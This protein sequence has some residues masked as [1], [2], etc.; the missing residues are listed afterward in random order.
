MGWKDFKDWCIEY[1]LSFLPASPQT[2]IAYLTDR[3]PTM[4]VKTLELRLLAIRNEHRM[5]RLDCYSNH[6][7][8]AQTMKGI[9]NVHGKPPV[10]KTPILLSDL[11]EMVMACKDDL[12]GKRDK[13]LL[14]LGFAGAFRR[15]ELV[16][17]K[18]EDLKFT[19]DGIEITL[20][21]CKTDQ[22][23]RGQIV[24]IPYGSSLCTCPVRAIQDWIE[25][26]KLT[27]G[28]LFLHFNTSGRAVKTQLSAGSVAI[29]IKTNPYLK[30]IEKDFSGHSLRAGFC[31]TAA[32]KGVQEHSIMRQSRIA[33]GDTLRKYI[34]M[35]TMWQDCAAT[36]VGL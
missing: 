34:R 33:C 28:Y 14:L 11:K 29:L 9:R 27:E 15:Q 20:N 21:K 10:Q 7:L 8:I 19:R 5:N 6:A 13:A 22:Q 1:S 18:L 2:I 12:K 4:K 23:G 17:I 16:N 30:G 25:S 35:G 24:P 31:T 36:K 26:A 32:M 3:A